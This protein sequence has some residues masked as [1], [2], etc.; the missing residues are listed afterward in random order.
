[1]IDQITKILQQVGL[2]DQLVNE[3]IQTGRFLKVREGQPLIEPG[4]DAKEMP[5]VINGTLR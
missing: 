5:L 3:I 4:M 1:M 2:E